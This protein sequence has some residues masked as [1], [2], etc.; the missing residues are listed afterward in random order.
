[1]IRGAA[2]EPPSGRSLSTDISNVFHPEQV[3]ALAD[4]PFGCEPTLGLERRFGDDLSCS[5][6]RGSADLAR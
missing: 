4:E 2:Y 6:E 3:L 1:L 5:L